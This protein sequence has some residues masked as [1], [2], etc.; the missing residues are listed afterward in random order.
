[1]GCA[2]R[3]LLK[4]CGLG[5]TRRDIMTRKEAWTLFPYVIASPCQPPLSKP[6]VSHHVVYNAWPVSRLASNSTRVDD[7]DL[8][9]VSV[10]FLLPRSCRVAR[11]AATT[12]N[13]CT[14][15][16]NVIAHLGYKGSAP[17]ATLLRP[18]PGLQ[19]AS[20]TRQRHLRKLWNVGK[21]TLR[22]D[23]RFI[24][25]EAPREPLAGG[26]PGINIQNEEAWPK[27]RKKNIQVCI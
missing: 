27:W 15:P 24:S 2:I 20:A 13:P 21:K 3:L 9:A 12:L 10:M 17:F 8:V 22:Q 7:G 25:L 11:S 19:E 23:A 14:N 26:E 5:R 18:S 1:M 6:R 4:G 16:G